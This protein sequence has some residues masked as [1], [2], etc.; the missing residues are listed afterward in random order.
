MI[1]TNDAPDSITLSSSPVVGMVTVDTIS[2][3]MATSV[4]GLSD[5]DTWYVLGYYAAGDGGGGLFFWD[6]ASSAADDGGLLITP[7]SN[8]A[9]GGNGFLT[10]GRFG[11]NGGVPK[12]M[13]PTMIRLRYRT[14]SAMWLPTVAW[15]GCR[16]ALT[17]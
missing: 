1:T 3:L 16:T 8:P 15:L 11:L 14:L 12:V 6:A 2:A 7:N 9:S 5:G 4:G 17:R 13:T 10:R